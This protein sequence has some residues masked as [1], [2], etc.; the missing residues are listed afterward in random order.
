MFVVR[1][2]DK[3]RIETMRP[4]NMIGLRQ[5]LECD[6]GLCVEALFFCRNLDAV[7]GMVPT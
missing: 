6:S 4:R 3:K 2:S 7:G 5:P 1:G